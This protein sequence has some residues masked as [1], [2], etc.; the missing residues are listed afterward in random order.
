M[1][2]QG[3]TRLEVLVLVDFEG[4]LGDELKIVAGDII[5]KVQPGPE[6]GWLQG[7]LDG[8]V[9]LFPQLFVQEIPTSL[10]ADGTQRYPR[11]L[12]S[13][14]ATKKLATTKQRWCQVTFPYVPAKED[15]LE[16]C[17]GDLV[18]ILKEIEDG[19]WLGEKGGQLGAFPSNFVQE[20]SGTSSDAFFLSPKGGAAKQ[21]PKMTNETF[22]LNET[23]KL[24]SPSEKVASPP[25]LPPPPPA[26]ETPK[27]QPLQEN[28]PG[29]TPR[30]CRAMFDYE[31]EHEDE[32]PIRKG[33]LILLLKKET[34][35]LGWWEGENR[36]KKG[37]F[38]DNFVI[39][40]THLEPGIRTKVPTR[41]KEAAKGVKKSLQGSKGEMRPL[42]DLKDFKEQ[43]KM[44][45]SKPNPPLPPVKKAAPPPPPVP[46]KA[47]PA[48]SVPQKSSNIPVSCTA[49][50]GGK[51]KSKET[52]NNTFDAVVVPG[53]K[54]THP[55]TSR[56]KMPGKR[57][58]SQLMA[59]SMVVEKGPICPTNSAE[60]PK[61]PEQVKVPLLSKRAES[62]IAVL[63]NPSSKEPLSSLEDFKAELRT[64]RTLMDLMHDQHRKDMEELKAEMSQEQTKRAALQAEIEWLK[65]T[66]PTVGLVDQGC[67]KPSG[68][69]PATLGISS[70]G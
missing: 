31:P 5:Q 26:Q 57:P 50:P 1:P 16:L 38:P 2:L 64:L 22:L 23:E 36:G 60:K 9:G 20:L 6:E 30:Y 3:V 10:R 25:P 33:D 58:P 15:E 54:L 28:A 51:A 7:E 17:P 21:R 55:T 18:Q 45:A 4:Q 61:S 43:K 27:A 56:P 65:Q 40:L 66:L 11:S 8:R 37:L 46:T 47:K 44:E 29:D 69:E 39:P 41:R 59:G 12:R 42:G 35:D 13:A 70:L 14:H 19:W 53:A 32:L 24:E 63:E 49:T 62:P 68:V 34:V 67:K 52:E 48:S